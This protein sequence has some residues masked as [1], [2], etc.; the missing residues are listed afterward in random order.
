ESSKKKKKKGGE[1]FVPPLPT[2]LHQP[3][4]HP[5]S[6]DVPSRTRVFLFVFFGFF[7]LFFLFYLANPVSNAALQTKGAK[8]AA[9]VIGFCVCLVFVVISLSRTTALL[10]N[11][12]APISV[13]SDLYYSHLVPHSQLLSGRLPFAQKNGNRF[14]ELINAQNPH[15]ENESVNICVG[16]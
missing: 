10:V 1:I 14:A 5:F 12:S 11:Y 6:L 16:K 7:L 13:F 3:R 4:D 8:S 9:R 15:P 2:S